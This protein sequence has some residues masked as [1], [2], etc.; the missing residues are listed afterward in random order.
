MSTPQ[1]INTF[2][3]PGSFCSLP[4]RVYSREE[5]ITQRARE[6]N[7]KY[8][9]LAHKV[10]GQ[11]HCDSKD[12]NWVALIYP[13]ATDHTRMLVIVELT[14]MLFFTDGVLNSR[15]SH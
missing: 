12:G 14:E 7:S 6:I 10:P 1:T 8:A 2:Q 4:T 13:Y 15:M 11:A 5:E 9:T 3:K